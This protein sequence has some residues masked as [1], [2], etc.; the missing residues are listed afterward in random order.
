MYFNGLLLLTQIIKIILEENYLIHSKL[1]F[2]I[3]I[4]YFYQR[5]LTSS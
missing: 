1:I 2:R 4:G 5:K 3:L